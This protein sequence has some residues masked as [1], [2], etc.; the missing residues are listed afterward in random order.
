MY[1]PTS[2]SWKLPSAGPFRVLEVPTPLNVVLD[3]PSRYKNHRRIHVSHIRPY[4]QDTTFGDRYTPPPAV[5]VDEEEE[6]EVSGIRSKRTK[7]GVVEY[8]VSYTGYDTHEDIWLPEE[9]LPI[10]KTS[11]RSSTPRG[12]HVPPGLTRRPPGPR[13]RPRQ[14]E[15]GD[16]SACDATGPFTHLI[17]GVFSLGPA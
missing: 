16:R 13:P 2:G 3:L 7:N 1:R 9:D 17:H 8:L 15:Q 14:E 4:I 10:A 11:S 12:R 5:M 6:W